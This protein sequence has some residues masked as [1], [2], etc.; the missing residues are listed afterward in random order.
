M[1]NAGASSSREATVFLP[2]T[3]SAAGTGHVLLNRQSMI[4]LLQL[5]SSSLHHALSAVPMF[6]PSPYASRRSTSTV[7]S[8]IPHPPHQ[9]PLIQTHSTNCYALYAYN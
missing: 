4:C 3:P 8:Q 6:V 7:V 5:S 2:K 1:D 9:T